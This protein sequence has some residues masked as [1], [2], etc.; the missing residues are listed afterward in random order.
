MDG[1]IFQQETNQKLRL[2]YDV[3]LRADPTNTDLRHQSE[4]LGVDK[5]RY[6]EK[7]VR[8][9]ENRTQPIHDEYSI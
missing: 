9:W 3:L 8:Q 5:S 1:A 7:I 6:C 2:L 4:K